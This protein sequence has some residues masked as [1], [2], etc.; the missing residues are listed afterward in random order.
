[1]QPDKTLITIRNNERLI[2]GFILDMIIT[3]GRLAHKWAAIT[4]QTPNLKIGYPAQHLASLITGM[5][6]T[7]TGAR[8]NDIIDGSEVKACS[9]VDQLDKCRNCG[10][11]VLRSAIVCPYCGSKDIKRNNDSK[12]LIAVRSEDEL[13]MLLE[14]TPRFI[15]IVTD[16]PE[17]ENNNF[18]DI[19]I[20]AFEIWVSS[21]RCKHFRELLGNYYNFIYKEHIYNNSSQTPA[22]KN[23]WPY[24][25]PFYMCNPIKVFECLIKNFL[26]GRP[27]IEIVHYTAPDISRKNLQSEIMPASLLYK[28]EMKLLKS[29]GFNVQSDGYVDENMRSYLQLRDTDKTIKIIG[30]KKHKN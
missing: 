25:F 4:N 6:G 1:M 29:K 11:G 23:L 10:H 27:R 16:Y 5:Q 19:R 12:W 3:P 17:F 2:K 21:K 9:K 30:T 28:D 14:E 8:G 18:S 13:R 26:S 24:K 22:P 20:R 7:A 15:F